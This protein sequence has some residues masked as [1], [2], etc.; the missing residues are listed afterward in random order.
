MNEFP[1]PEC[2]D[3]VGDRI[4]RERTADG[5]KTLFRCANCDH[6]WEVIF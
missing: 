1:C 2:A 6:S 3:G 4:S 5:I